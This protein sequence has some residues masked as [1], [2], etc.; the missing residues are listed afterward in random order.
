MRDLSRRDLLKA[1]A[2]AAAGAVIVPSVAV[3]ITAGSHPDLVPDGLAARA[4]MKGV[5]FERHEKV[6]IGIVGTGLRGRSVLSELLAIEGVQITVLCDVV[7]EKVARASKMCV[8]AGHPQPD[9]I[10]AGDKGFEELV[11]SDD[12]DFVYTATPWEWHVPVMLAALKAGKHCGSECPIGTTLKDLWALVDAS[13]KARRHCLQLEN[14]NYGETEMLVNRLVHEGV[15]G[16]IL[17]AEAAYLHDLRKILFEDRDE[18]LWRRAWHTRSN[19][20]L[21]P[22]HGL[23]PVSWYLDVHAGDRYDYIVSVGGPHRGLELHREA[24][25]PD[26][27]NAKWK[28]AYVTGDH[29]TSILKTVKGKTVMLQHDVS[30]PRPY[31]RHNRVQGT[32]GAFEDYPPRIYV[33]GQAGGERWATVDDWKAKFT[34]PLWQKYGAE[35]RRVGGHGGMDYIMAFRLVQTMRE[36]IV[37]DFDVYDA[38][39][40]SAP[41]PLSEISIA[42]G[43][44]P[45]KFPDFT[46]GAFASA[47]SAT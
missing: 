18:G 7:G 38:A 37:P 47:R 5:P 6:R 32:K 22:T 8:D 17:H 41:L 19:S 40:W 14:C 26:K 24:T 34:H 13:E 42:K 27:T 44:S 16:E 15:F 46:R 39:T 31:T 10:I 9:A 36:G 4:T 33:E 1:A 28:E 25:V 2:G 3:A 11:K 23:G 12:V 43:S 35:A 20:N 21:Y 30:N 45:V 29:N